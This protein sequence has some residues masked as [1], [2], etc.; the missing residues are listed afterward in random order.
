MLEIYVNSNIL[1]VLYTFALHLKYNLNS[2]SVLFSP[3]IKIK[4]INNFK[5]FLF[6]TGE[7]VSYLSRNVVLGEVERCDLP[8]DELMVLNAWVVS[9][10]LFIVVWVTFHTKKMN[11]TI[12]ISYCNG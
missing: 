3:V 10:S 8:R 6:Y 12:F 4:Y 11:I 7:I 5:V 2:N 9:V 1:R